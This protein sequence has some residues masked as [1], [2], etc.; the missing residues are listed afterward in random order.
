MTMIKFEYL[1]NAARLEQE[2]AKVTLPNL[3]A[4]LLQQ[5][6]LYRKLANERAEN[7]PESFGTNG[8]VGRAR[9]TPRYTAQ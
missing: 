9:T 5:A 4:V 6:E 1:E 8:P 3:K 7:R 2:A